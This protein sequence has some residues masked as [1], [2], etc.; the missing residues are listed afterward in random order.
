VV[1][2]QRRPLVALLV[3]ATVAGAAASA[4]ADTAARGG[5]GSWA[6]REIAEVVGQHVLG[7]SVASFR[8]QAL[9]TQGQLQG[10]LDRSWQVMSQPPPPPPCDDPAGCGIDPGPAPPA[11]P[12]P[13]VAQ[14]P[15]APVTVK[16]LD[17]AIVTQLGLLPTASA[18]TGTLSSAGL[19]PRPRTGTEIVARLLGLRTNHPASEDGLEILPDQPATRAEAAY[20]L[21]QMLRAGLEGGAWVNDL[22]PSFQL[23]EL[24]AWQ[25]RILTTATRFV[26]YP[27]IWGGTSEHAETEFGI[28]SR[29]GF[30]CSGFVWRVYKLQPYPGERRLAGVLRGRTTFDMSG[31][32]KGAKRIALAKLQPADVIFFG[33]RGPRS[34]P[35]QVGHMGIYLGNG[36]FIHSSGA[37]VTVV[38]LAGWYAKQFAWARRPLREAGLG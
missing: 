28:R 15:T 13:Y 7:D 36:W 6:K 10:A 5:S 9:L 31:E 18:F 38:P 25:R 11:N 24:S 26:G 30:D 12:H 1:P 3:V 34:R 2:P 21:A 33:D 27:Y 8:P 16:E 35:S 17:A 22:A 14:A 20:S 37:G 23:P 29:G 19:R 4:S 32:V